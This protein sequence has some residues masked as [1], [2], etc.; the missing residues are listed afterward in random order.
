MRSGVVE[1]SAAVSIESPVG[2]CDGWGWRI[3]AAAAARSRIDAT[4]RDHQSA[5]YEESAVS[6]TVDEA[7]GGGAFEGERVAFRPL[8]RSA[9]RGHQ[10]SITCIVHIPKIAMHAHRQGKP[11]TKRRAR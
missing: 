8:V 2:G 1:L 5:L 10:V 11:R 4:T 3:N 7:R 9:T 6:S